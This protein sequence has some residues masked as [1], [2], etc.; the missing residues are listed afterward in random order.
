M[1]EI[2]LDFIHEIEQVNF[3]DNSNIKMLYNKA[4]EIETQLISIDYIGKPSNIKRLIEITDKLCLISN[5]WY[6]LM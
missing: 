2:V 5:E 3:A 6:T 4:K 1:K